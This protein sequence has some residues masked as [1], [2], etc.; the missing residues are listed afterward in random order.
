M[1]QVAAELHW[2]E[3]IE[4]SVAMPKAMPKVMPK[5]MPKALSDDVAIATGKRDR[6]PRETS[7]TLRQSPFWSRAMLWGLLG[8]VSAAL[9]WACLAQFEEAIPTQGQLKPQGAVKDVQAP[10]E[11][12]VKAVFVQDGQRVKKG[13]RLLSLDP[14]TANAQLASLNKIKA[15]LLEENR[16]Y[17][18]Q[19][20]G[21]DPFRNS[22]F[23]SLNIP[24][25]IAA[26]TKNRSSLL[27]ENR[28]FE[29]QIKGNTSDPRF[30][31]D[32]TAR[33]QSS[34]ADLDSRIG[35]SQYERDQLARQ[36]DQAQIQLTQAKEQGAVNQK[37]LNDMAPLVKDG[38]IA[39]VQYLRQEQEVSGHR[40]DADR[41]AQERARLQFAMSQSWEQQR[42][43]YAQFE[44]EL[45][46]K[47]ADNTKQ[48]A[49]IDD[50]L[51][52]AI[53]ENEK[54]LA[55]ID[56]QMSQAT[57][58][59]QYQELVAPVDG[60][61]F[62]LQARTPGYVTKASEAVVKVVP[63]DA[64]IAEVSITNKDIGFVKPQM[65]VDVRIDSF[66][67]SEFGDI[68]GEVI[69]VG[70]D[71]LPPTQA[72]PYYSFPAKIHLDK[73]ALALHDRDVK[74]QSGMS[75][76]ANIKVRKRSVMSI[77]TE[78][79]MQQADSLKATR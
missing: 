13:D 60:T 47:M 64:L 18:L 33:I 2:I 5:V 16:F 56:S 28:V 35:A 48:I 21:V 36:I 69:W 49:Q 3:P 74:L 37:I 66:P 55:E 8:I 38:A 61:V 65:P 31:P 22:S 27:A 71:A 45:R 12:V 11:G 4:W 19:F 67:F 79:F 70:S 42:T 15:A 53:V 17:R 39:R 52:K 29:A 58:T 72:R 10:V 75:I 32:E 51:N 73:Q 76:N 6:P 7:V 14:T 20:M 77:F 26:L 57:L 62:D 34:W 23:A 25:T 68:K 59:L 46:N 54:R 41:F 44:R 40:A 24:P 43:I 1:V 9:T 78:L 63:D 30:S 50:Q